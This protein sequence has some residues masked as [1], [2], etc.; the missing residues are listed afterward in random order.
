LGEFR[1]WPFVLTDVL[2]KEGVIGHS[3]LEPYRV[4]ATKSIVALIEDMAEQQRGKPVAPFDRFEEAVRSLHLLGR[5]GVVLIAI[6]ALD[7]AMWD[8]LAKA[9]GLPLVV[10]LDGTVGPVR[11]YN[12]NGLWLIPLE[13]LADEASSL[14]AEGDFKAIKIRLGC[15]NV[16]DD[17]KAIAEVRRAVGDDIIL[18][19]DF[20]Q[21]LSF[22]AA[23]RR[24]HQLDDQ[25]LE[26]FE[27]PI[28]F[29]DFANSARLANELKTPL[30]IGEN[31]YGR[32]TS[33]RLSQRAR[34]TATCQTWSGSEASRHGL[35]SIGSDRRR[36]RPTDVDTSLSRILCPSDACHGNRGLAG[37]A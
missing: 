2:T 33:Y 9:L 17:L 4:T 15:D 21:G 20:N 8:A 37:M 25:G 34:R 35:A 5:Q 7:M 11:A 24:L 1:Q 3:Y 27:E 22:N 12:T 28:V 19:S 26:W 29:D 36:P 16:K 10:M 14:A 6:A 31:I 32:G 18:M 23:L 30:Q 13:R